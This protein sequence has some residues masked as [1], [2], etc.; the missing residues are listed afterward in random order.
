VLYTFS[1]QSWRLIGVQL[2][3]GVGA[4]IF[5]AITPLMIADLMRGTGRFNVAQGAVATMQGIGA[6]ASGLLAGELVG[7]AG[8]SA[9]FLASGAIAVSALALWYLMPETASDVRPGLAMRI[10]RNSPPLLLTHSMEQAVGDGADEEAQ[11]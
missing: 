11:D 1:D 5:G 3:D 7:Q 4:G 10:D 2:L 9:A 8:Y 6:S